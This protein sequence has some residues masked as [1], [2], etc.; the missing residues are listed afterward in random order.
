MHV[1]TGESYLYYAVH[2]TGSE[3]VSYVCGYDICTYIYIYMGF[4]NDTQQISQF[5]SALK[6]IVRRSCLH[7]F[8]H[9][10]FYCF[11]PRVVS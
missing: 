6:V 2:L 8:F 10:L 7:M 1:A 5:F 3:E 9:Y 4:F 11:L